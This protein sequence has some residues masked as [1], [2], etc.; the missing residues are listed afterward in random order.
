M[1]NLDVIFNTIS[2]QSKGLTSKITPS[3]WNYI[4]NVLSK[5][6]NHNA[7]VLKNIKNMFQRIIDS[8]SVGQEEIDELKNE[9]QI[10]KE[11][12]PRKA[13]L[14][15]GKVPIEQ[16]PEI[17]F[18]KDEIYISETASYQE[19]LKVWIKPIEEQIEE[20]PMAMMLMSPELEVEEEP[21]QVELPEL[22]V[23]E[24]QTQVELPELEIEEEK[25]EEEPP[26]LVV[27]SE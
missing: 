22:E 2:Q 11:T 4:V 1:D 26:E 18:S 23:E 20:D 6:S 19:G 14:I 7:K 15:D 27:Q 12:F 3:E 24:E 5:Q 17:D 16:I 8:G 9:I 25:T 13:D 21:P 10:I